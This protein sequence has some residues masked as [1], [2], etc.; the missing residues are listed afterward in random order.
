[1]T[2]AMPDGTGL[3]KFQQAFPDRFYD[4]GIAEQHGVT[5]CAGMALEGL[6]PVAAIYSTFLQRAYDQIVH[7]V[8]LMDLPVTFA[9]DR[10]G[11]VGQDGT[12]HHGIYDLA[13]LRTLPH[14]HVMAPK[15]ENELQHMLKTCIECPHPAAVRYPRGSGLG[16]TLDE[17]LHALEIGKGEQLREG[18]D[19][20]L[21]ALGSMVHPA[22][23]AAEMLH[24]DGVEAGVI[25]ARFVK[26]LD[27]ALILSAAAR[28][29]LL[30][31]LE[32]HSEHGGFASS[33]LEMLADRRLFDIKIL[34]IAVP[35]RIIPHGPPDLLY[36]KYGLDADGIYHRVKI[37]LDE[38]RN[39][40]LD[41]TS[42]SSRADSLK[43][44]K[45]P[46]P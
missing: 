46:T 18:R 28:T 21:V 11:L 2:A 35:D 13:Y 26:P 8:C 33:V 19:L 7:D 45:R 5:F 29:G 4:V 37:F 9:L 12:T 32:D 3:D 23:T 38:C 39:R 41:L 1:I 44:V 27:E 42:Y 16:V 25:N 10:A 24:K 22:L 34:R 17:E 15:D 31:M 40:K 6:K 20:A 14:M 30:V 36:A 43:I